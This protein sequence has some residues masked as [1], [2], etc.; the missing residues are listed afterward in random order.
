MSE[1]IKR[2]VEIKGVVRDV[3]DR[4]HDKLKKGFVYVRDELE[5]ESDSDLIYI[6]GGKIKKADESLKPGH[7]YKG[8][9]GNLVFVD[10]SEEDADLYDKSRIDVFGNEAVIAAVNR[11]N[12]FK[13]IDPR[14]VEDADKWYMPEIEMG[15]DVFKRVVKHALQEKKV[16]LKACRDRFKND[17]DVTN[18]KQ[19]LRKDSMLSNA[20][21]HKWAEVLD[22]HVVIQVEL[23]SSEG[24]RIT[25]SETMR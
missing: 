16:S 4:V 6:Y 13:D 18:M 24:E 11:E 1:P 5:P 15:D 17:Y 22:L 21:L 19:A 3:L 8:D 20:Y 14:V 2:L 10:P 25:F 7:F 9:D 12:E 23:T